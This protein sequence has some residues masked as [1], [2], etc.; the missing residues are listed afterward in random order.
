[1]DDLS[2]H[3]SEPDPGARGL[4]RFVSAWGALG[5]V[6]VS[7]AAWLALTSS[8]LGPP[9]VW[10]LVTLFVLACGSLEVSLPLGRRTLAFDLAET[11]LVVALV[12]VPPPGTVLAMTA[13]LLVAN[14]VRRHAAQ[15]VAFN[16]AVT[17]V[18]ATAAAVVVGTGS[19]VPLNATDPPDLL[20]LIAAI[21]VYG[22]VNTLAAALLLMRLDGTTFALTIG[23]ILRGT[24]VSVALSGSLGL[25]AAV[26]LAAVPLAIPALFL[27]AWIT[28]RALVERVER[29][30]A[31][32]AVRDR[33]ERTVEGA[34]DGIVLL[35]ATGSVELANP[36]ACHRL[37]VPRGELVG[38]D[39]VERLR[40][41]RVEEAGLLR[42]LLDA[43]EPADPSGEVDL[44]L[45]GAVYTL[46]LTGLFDRLG[47]RSGTVALL[48]DVTTQRETEGIRREFV[49][50]VSHELRT[51][52]TSI[53]GFI[54]T[55]RRHDGRF[56]AE[57]RQH[58]LRI[59]ERQAARLD[60]LVSTL[61]WSA[62]LER[63]RA[64][65]LPTEVDISEAVAQTI[66]ILGDALP[67][68][69][70]VELGT[71]RVWV[72]EDHLQQVL[73]NLLVNAA[74]Y[75]RPPIAI[76]AW[77]ADGRGVVIEVSDGGPGVASG[78]VPELF[79]PF[80]QASTG[81]RRTACG[82]GLGLSITRGLLEANG[83]RIA[84][85]RA[86]G[87]TCFRFS[88]PLAEGDGG[89][90]GGDGG[91]AEGDGAVGGGLGGEIAAR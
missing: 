80:S 35:D 83:G 91:G 72:D 30:R 54:T 90:A 77:G 59:I 73:G 62:R 27:P 74:T 20:L 41:I 70:E 6:G 18:A 82:L 64:A 52:L 23:G 69:V 4:R 1:M 43:L 84:Y 8:G 86:G 39:L 89:G 15:Q 34:N 10:S 79:S 38:T 32:V 87:R 50:R 7:G 5:L 14:L 68:D 75:G 12:L 49:A 88:L 3:A 17:A 55:M 24:S 2:P 9:V 26:L 66:Q 13:G 48:L 45:D 29:I 65:P 25:I 11:G 28:Y 37:G 19:A 44:H 42:A 81:D 63:D 78:F 31:E 57:Q 60:R 71:H 85:V 61:L 56:T 40:G 67:E 58:Y 21:V 16:A 46:A 47:G 36:A 53:M 51:P 33:L 76:R 22:L